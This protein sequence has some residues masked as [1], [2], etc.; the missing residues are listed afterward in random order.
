MILRIS[1]LCLLLY[2]NVFPH[3]G[4][5]QI[6]DNK[7]YFDH[8]TKLELSKEEVLSYNPPLKVYP[9]RG[10][11]VTNHM[12][13][14]TYPVEVLK[15]LTDSLN[16]VILKHPDNTQ[17][18]RALEKKDT[19][20]ELLRS[21]CHF[22][23][24]RD[25]RFI[26]SSAVVSSIISSVIVSPVTSVAVTSALGYFDNQNLAEEELKL[27][28]HKNRKEKERDTY[29]RE[30]MK[31][32]QAST[33]NLTDQ[34]DVNDFAKILKMD[35]NQ[36][37]N[38][39]SLATDLESYKFQDSQLLKNIEAKLMNNTDFVNMIQNSGFGVSG[40]T[41]LLSLSE[42]ESILVS[43]DEGHFCSNSAIMM[44]MKTIVPDEDY[45]VTP[46]EKKYKY[47]LDE[48]HSVYMSPAFFLPKSRF[49][50][51]TVFNTQRRIVAKD[52]A[53]SNIIPFNNSHFFVETDGQFT[54][55]KTC[56]NQSK[57]FK[58]FKNPYI[59]VPEFCTLE[60]EMLNISE[61]KII[62]T[63]SENANSEVHRVED[64]DFGPLYDVEDSL[65]I[66][67]YMMKEKIEEIFNLKQ[68]ITQLHK[69]AVEKYNWGERVY[70]GFSNLFSV[71]ESGLKSAAQDIVVDPF[72]KLMSGLIPLFI[73]VCIGLWLYKKKRGRK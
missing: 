22:G 51:H 53:V 33:K 58:L 57:T 6:E 60:S 68:H 30:R 5:L 52:K 1:I 20:E 19:A 49:R 47:S 44:K 73:L 50:T 13:N 9:A 63:L 48:N 3:D 35:F 28:E 38:Y 8:K 31:Q 24:K 64:L 18:K 65:I 2:K 70:E 41:A 54:V 26:I 16:E 67:D 14:L 37:I 46:T 32:I 36:I 59:K 15:N 29:Y 17:A 4:F 25:K 45:E 34:M 11:A 7:Q 56:Q 69:E 71:I 55:R 66:E 21:L 40:Q 72:Y 43:E 23:D 10:L 27:H 62:F 12:I 39:F 61:F 42:G